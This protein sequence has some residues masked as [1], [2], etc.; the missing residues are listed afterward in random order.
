MRWI[1]L[2]RVLFC[3]FWNISSTWVLHTDDSS[4][5]DAGGLMIPTEVWAV[6]I[7]F[8]AASLPKFAG[9]SNERDS[10][11]LECFAVPG[12]HPLCDT[13][14]WHCARRCHHPVCFMTAFPSLWNAVSSFGQAFWTLSWKR[15]KLFT[16][17]EGLERKWLA[18]AKAIELFSSPPQSA[19][20]SGLAGAEC[21]WKCA[22]GMH[23]HI[24]SNGIYIRAGEQAGAAG[25][26]GRNKLLLGNLWQRCMYTSPTTHLIQRWLSSVFIL[27]W[28]GGSEGPVRVPRY[29][30]RGIWRRRH[31]SFAGKPTHRFLLGQLSD[32]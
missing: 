14:I 22:F 24:L 30:H 13:D 4:V 11:P 28:W 1:V 31:G 27:P 21:E 8:R 29:M 25:G 23:V 3:F 9:I 32:I 6:F 16:R 19:G 10:L 26:A 15:V 5:M 17:G 2:K 18:I 20:L 12:R 7:L